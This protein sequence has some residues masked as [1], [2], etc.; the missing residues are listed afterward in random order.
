MA[1]TKCDAVRAF[2]DG[3]AQGRCTPCAASCSAD[4]ACTA[5]CC[6]PGCYDSTKS[7]APGYCQVGDLAARYDLA[8][9][10]KYSPSGF[11][12]ADRRMIRAREMQIDDAAIGGFEQQ[13]GQE[14]P[15]VA[16]DQLGITWFG[17]TKCMVNADGSGGG[18]DSSRYFTRTGLE[19]LGYS[20]RPLVA[21]PA[22]QG[23]TPAWATRMVPVWMDRVFSPDLAVLMIFV[24]L[25]VIFSAVIYGAYRWSKGAAVRAAVARNRAREEA[26]KADPY[27]GTAFE[28]W[29]D[30][31]K[32]IRQY[33]ES[34]EAAGYDM[35]AYRRQYNLPPKFAKAYR[36]PG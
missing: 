20:P 25:V 26:E 32:K 19:L 14:F 15:K 1:T 13:L 23:K 34:Q 28:S 10:D 5:N 7:R 36:R 16:P 33:I 8:F 21:V 3:S 30:P 2:N 4:L 22:L 9:N 29:P 24:L 17:M 6:R 18:P 31:N 27:R 35:G 11:I 12:T